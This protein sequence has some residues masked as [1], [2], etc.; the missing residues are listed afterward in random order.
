ME[1]S[2]CANRDRCTT[3]N[4]IFI[5]SPSL[6]RASNVSG[7]GSKIVQGRLSW[8]KAVIVSGDSLGVYLEMKVDASAHD[9]S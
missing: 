5:R 4:S 8:I 2:L 3:A 6:A 1:C 7:T 9:L